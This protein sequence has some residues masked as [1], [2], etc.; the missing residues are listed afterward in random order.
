[1][2]SGIRERSVQNWGV[3]RGLAMTC[4]RHNSNRRRHADSSC[5]SNLAQTA[6]SF[7]MSG[8]FSAA[9][10]LDVRDLGCCPTSRDL[11]ENGSRTVDA[12]VQQQ[13]Q[14]GDYS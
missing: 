13:H 5:Q 1:V 6:R 11:I 10:C 3:N 7:A 12:A 4:D 14:Q 9:V 2:Q 8:A